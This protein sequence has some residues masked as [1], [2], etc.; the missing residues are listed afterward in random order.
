MTLFSFRTL[1]F[2]WTGLAGAAAVSAA[3]LQAS[4][5]PPAPPPAEPAIAAV[6]LP[7]PSSVPFENRSL[8]AMLPPAE[9][10]SRPPSHLDARA[11]EPLPVPPVPPMRTARTEP[12]R[13]APARTYV[14]EPTYASDEPSYPGWGWRGRL[15]YPGQYAM[16]RGYYY[17][18][19]PGYGWQP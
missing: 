14:A 13:Y 18:P 7:K 19:Q 6:V 9:S 12:R 11:A 16:G 17:G 1:A 15:P 10:H 2:A 8:L 4:Y 5:V 3:V